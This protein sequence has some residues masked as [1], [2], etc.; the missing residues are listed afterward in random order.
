M[1]LL[2]CGFCVVLVLKNDY[3]SGLKAHNPIL[4][5]HRHRKT[6]G[7]LLS[8]KLVKQYKNQIRITHSKSD[9]SKRTDSHNR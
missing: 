8:Y 1:N 4:G 9:N 6:V 5:L 7:C 2:F 3:G